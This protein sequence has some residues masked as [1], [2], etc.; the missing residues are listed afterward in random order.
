MSSDAILVLVGKKSEV[1]KLLAGMVSTQMVCM[2]D[3]TITLEKIPPSSFVV[4]FRT[5]GQTLSSVRRQTMGGTSQVLHTYKC[6]S[7]ETLVSWMQ[8]GRQTLP[9]TNETVSNAD[10]HRLR[11]LLTPAIDDDPPPAPPSPLTPPHVTR[12]RRR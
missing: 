4:L 5:R 7:V 9:D 1:R 3:D 10:F 8:S 11:T 2:S 12:R 6:Y